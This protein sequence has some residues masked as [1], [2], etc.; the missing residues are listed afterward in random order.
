MLL[1]EKHSAGARPA[2]YIAERYVWD[3]QNY[4]KAEQL[5]S[6]S[7]P[8][9]CIWKDQRNDA[10]SLKQPPRIFQRSGGQIMARSG[11]DMLFGELLSILR[12]NIS[13]IRAS[14]DNA[15][16]GGPINHAPVG[17]EMMADFGKRARV[18]A[19]IGVNLCAFAFGETFVRHSSFDNIKASILSGTPPI[20]E[21]TH[22]PQSLPENDDVAKFF[23]AAP[24]RHHLCM[25]D[26][27]F[28][29]GMGF[30][31]VFSIRLYGGAISSFVITR[32]APSITMVAPLFMLVDYME[33]KINLLSKARFISIYLKS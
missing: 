20:H 13:A 31:I 17:V 27:V 24:Q 19:K 7:A 33:H 16:P 11:A 22:A 8:K 30:T 29:P 15:G 14:A 2:E 18:L 23:L 6:H 9:G 3:G 26:S 12:R 10:N 32:S 28:V 21:K 1:V 4:Q 5:I 25:L